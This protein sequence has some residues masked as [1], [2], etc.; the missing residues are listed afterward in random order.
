VDEIWLNLARWAEVIRINVVFSFD[1]AFTYGMGSMKQIKLFNVVAATLASV[2]MLASQSVALAA[3]PQIAANPPSRGASQQ[4]TDVAL[5]S[6]GT[7]RGQ[8]VSVNGAPMANAEVVVRFGEAVV[9][10]T[11]TDDRGYFVV[12]G[13]QGG[14]YAITAEGAS[15]LYRLWAPNT[16]PPTAQGGAMLVAG[17]DVVR[18]QLLGL[19]GMNTG[20]LVML[21]IAG[22][23]VTAG[24]IDQDKGS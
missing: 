8:L 20:T 13:L 14:V 23:I 16:A 15:S 24:L 5:G 17:N 6:G 7:L 3:G 21:G 2:G 1:W 10:V 12:Q 9:A 22:G 19:G 18:G 4:M 11:K